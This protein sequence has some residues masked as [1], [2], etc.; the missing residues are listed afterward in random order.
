MNIKMIL[1]FFNFV[2]QLMH[3]NCVKQNDSLTTMLNRKTEEYNQQ[4]LRNEELAGQNSEQTSKIESQVSCPLILYNIHPPK[5]PFIHTSIYPSTCTSIHTFKHSVIHIM[6]VHSFIPPFNSSIL[7][8]N[9]MH[10][11]FY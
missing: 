7:H 6:Y 5:L 4:M 11:R 1:C 10:F 2:T 9:I 3:D 8:L